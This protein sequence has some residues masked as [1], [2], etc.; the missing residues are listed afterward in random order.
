MENNT[1][2]TGIEGIA[3]YIKDLK[4]KKAVV[5]GIDPENAYSEV[6]TL[7]S[8][9][10]EVYNEE[11]KKKTEAEKKAEALEAELNNEK[12]QNEARLRSIEEQTIQHLEKSRAE[13][14]ELK[15]RLEAA[16]SDGEDRV[17]AQKRVSMLETHISSL[18]TTIDSLENEN[19]QLKE[20]LA[21]AEEKC[22]EVSFRNE[23]LEEI[24]LDANRKRVDIVNKATADA[25]KMLKDAE[26]Q[27][28]F[29]KENAAKENNDLLQSNTTLK[30]ENEE[31]AGK[32][33][34]KRASMIEECEKE[35]AEI[36][37]KNES[38]LNDMLNTAQKK[39]DDILKEATLKAEGMLADAKAQNELSIAKAEDD[40]K[41][42]VLK[43]EDKA[44][45]ILADAEKE[46]NEKKQA[47]EKH[48][49]SAKAA[50]AE[51]SKKYNETAR[52]LS[53]LRADTLQTIQNDMNRLQ[54]LV[55]ELS[56]NNIE[57]FEEK[58]IDDE[59]R[60]QAEEELNQ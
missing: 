22:A 40:A 56:T 10:N 8:M 27:C 3:E 55:F 51:E 37:S 33:E 57:I 32:I 24:Y 26:E 20:R 9:F 25:E 39:A 17:R 54:E 4:F 53:S 41:V 5:G 31:L 44:R 28:K 42:I 2:K 30:N 38:T 49:A 12:S 19:S 11:V 16:S 58:N 48:I 35:A 43:A 60:R 7:I 13:N 34:A 6:R 47:A 45:G 36:R 52:K 1:K 29:I 18:E 23:T 46:A 15:K 21:A 50:Y 59:E 14:K